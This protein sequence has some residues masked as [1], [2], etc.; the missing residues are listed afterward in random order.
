MGDMVL[1]RY[2]P[3]DSILHRMDP[4]A[5]IICMLFLL[6]AI[7]I[8]AGYLGYVILGGLVISLILLSKLKI[9]YILKA[10]KPMMF[11]LVFLLI[12]NI[13]VIKSGNLLLSLGWFEVYDDA[14]FQTLFIVVRL[15]LMISI[16]TLLTA[17]TKP[18]DLTL[19]I[20]DLLTPF[21]RIG[22]PAH[23]IAMMISIALRFI[24]TL[25]EETQ[26]IMKAQASRG[27]DFEEGKFTEKIRGILSLIVPL[28][29]SAF[30]RAE[31]LAYAMEARGYAPDEERTRY[32][33]LKLTGMD[34]MSMLLCFA[35]LIGLIG[36][37]VL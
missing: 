2:L 26:R 16:T 17:T 19:G 15:A 30:Q 5:K 9:T 8:P 27:V 28:F 1:G 7:F 21:K 22:V 10:V 4:R 29:I 24:P 37:I 31:D 34:I 33:Q 11:M 18:L 36:Y 13:L 32:K 35:V 3:L 14:I 23:I 25:I 12:I 20:E 6:I